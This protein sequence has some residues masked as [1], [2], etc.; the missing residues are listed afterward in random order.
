[1]G[2]F[3]ITILA[4]VYSS[5]GNAE[6]ETREDTILVFSSRKDRAENSVIWFG[7][8]SSS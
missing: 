7:G 1:M 3:Q 5:R 4:R 6:L 8:Y 2:Q